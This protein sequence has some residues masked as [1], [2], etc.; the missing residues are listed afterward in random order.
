M[1][2]QSNRRGRPKK[3]PDI[4]ELLVAML[5]EVVMRLKELIHSDNEVIAFQAIKVFYELDIAMKQIKRDY[6]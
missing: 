4:D 5:P 1:K 2:A 3:M 6:E